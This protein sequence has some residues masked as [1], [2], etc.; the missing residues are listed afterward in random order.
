MNPRRVF[1]IIPA[2]GHSRRMRQPKLL[3]PWRDATIIESVLRAWCRSNV[4]HVIVVLREDD[5]SLSIICQE[6]PVEIVR[7]ARDPRD[8]KES[9]QCGLK[10]VAE[11]H[12]PTDRDQWIVAPADLPQLDADLINQV[13]AA[14]EGHSG[15]T[16]ARFG[17]RQ[18]HPILLP[19]T[20]SERVFSLAENAGL[21][22]LL[23]QTRVHF[24]DLPAARRVVDVDTPEE[25]EQLK[26]ANLPGINLP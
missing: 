14:G 10:H 23:E 2:A 22:H 18:G 19:W 20:W 16:A 12:Q 1:A 13:V 17:D 15:V 6:W 26:V 24:V 7:P 3:L 9:I 5:A 25:Y 21:D 11:T 4:S 8:M